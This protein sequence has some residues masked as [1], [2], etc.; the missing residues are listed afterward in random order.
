VSGHAGE[1]QF[2]ELLPLLKEYDIFH[3][4]GA[5]VGNNASTNDTLCRVIQRYLKEEKGLNWSAIFW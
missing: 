2:D 1:D 4:L 5:I 3:K